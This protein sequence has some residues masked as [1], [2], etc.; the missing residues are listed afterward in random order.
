MITVADQFRHTLG[1][2]HG[3]ADQSRFSVRQRRH[4]VIKMGKMMGAQLHG[5]RRAVI[6]RSRMAQ[7][8][9][10]LVM[11]FTDKLHSAVHIR[12]QRHQ[13]HPVSGQSVQFPEILRV[14]TADPFFHMSAFLLRI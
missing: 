9:A 8:D 6:T 2:V 4:G 1:I 11:H 3:R 5:L 13:F 10:H 12:R 14:R 7:G